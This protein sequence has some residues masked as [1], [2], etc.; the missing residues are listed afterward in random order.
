MTPGARRLTSP[1]GVTHTFDSSSFALELLLTGGP[2]PWDRYETLD[3]PEALAD[4]VVGSH[5][6]LGLPAAALKIT[7]AE[8]ARIKEFREALWRIIPALTKSNGNDKVLP[9]AQPVTPADLKLVNAAVGPL[10]RPQLGGPDRTKRW[11]TPVTGTQILGAAARELVEMIGTDR[12]K[13]VR[14][15]EGADCYL[16]FYDTSRPGNRRWCSMQRC[17]NR[18]KVGT[19]RTRHYA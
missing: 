2:P 15:C 8:L 16:M 9:G 12:A 11:E 14:M 19:Y 1:D 18:N 5:L 13:R 10:P 4:W 6:A 3:T 17:G 7:R